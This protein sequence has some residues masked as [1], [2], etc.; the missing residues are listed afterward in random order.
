MPSS[1]PSSSPTIAVDTERFGGIARLYGAGALERLAA[2]HVAVIGVGGVGSW[3][4]EALVR[5]GIGRITLI[6]LDDLCVT[7]TN[8][9]LPAMTGTIGRAKVEVMAERARAIAPLVQVETCLEFF[10]EESAEALF[11]PSW[12]WVVDAIDDV[13]AKCLLLA[14]C[15]AAGVPVVASGGAGGRIDPTQVRLVDLSESGADPLLRRV[16]KILRREHGFR[17]FDGTPWGIPTVCSPERPVFPWSDGTVCEQPELDVAS[18][19]RLDCNSGFGTASFVTA[20]FGF[21]A[22]S[23]V[24]TA[25]ARG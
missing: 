23:Q 5:S 22:A 20:T 6:D 17:A 3:A 10:T 4:V 19:L 13:D 24:I 11:N 8:R 7:N 25:I 2:A 21:V 18:P 1:P 16:R 9:Q 12:T 14:K 15:R